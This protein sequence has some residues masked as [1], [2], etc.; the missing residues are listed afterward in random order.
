M[1][2]DGEG[3]ESKKLIP[4]QKQNKYP[5]NKKQTQEKFF[6]IWQIY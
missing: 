6:E 3:R 1:W 5:N 4:S 2:F